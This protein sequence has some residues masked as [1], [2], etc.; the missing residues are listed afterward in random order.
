M[1]KYLGIGSLILLVLAPVLRLNVF[2]TH[3]AFE[4]RRFAFALILVSIVALSVSAVLVRVSTRGSPWAFGVAAVIMLCLFQWPSFNSLGE[5]AARVFGPVLGQGV[6]PVLVAAALIWLSVRLATQPAFHVLLFA[7]GLVIATS[8]LLLVLE[9]SADT[10]TEGLG[11]RA[12]LGLGD[13]NNPD[14]FVIVLDAYLRNDILKGDLGYD[15]S[16]FTSFLEDHSL[17]VPQFSRSNY[18]STFASLSSMF[19]MDYILEPG[20]T[21]PSDMATA[22]GLLRGSG[23]AVET[24]RAAGYEFNYLESPWSVSACGPGVDV[25]YPYWTLEETA[26][27]LGEFTIFA[28]IIEAGSW[29]ASSDRAL[30]QFEILREIAETDSDSPRLV[31]AHVGIPHPPFVLDEECHKWENPASDEWAV[32]PGTSVPYLRQLQC[33]NNK[34]REVIE[35]IDRLDSDTVVL[36]TA[37]HGVPLHGQWGAPIDQWSWEHLEESLATFSA[38]RLPAWCEPAQEGEFELVNSFR[39]VIG[40]LFDQD[41]G[42]IDSRFFHAFPLDNA[43]IDM[44]EVSARRP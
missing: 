32:T 27:W 8:Q 15:N 36:L 33:V 44:A 26:K 31:Y 10:E 14:V 21:G 39:I 40:C 25:C 38:Y 4:F 16:E 1:A 5:G 35:A 11:T 2:S 13:H 6:L 34:V 28:P 7:A 42:Q 12:A 19:G 23:P 20:H 17:H 22:R 43:T 29:E 24:F 9:R 37:D 30:E 18:N 41:P 3:E